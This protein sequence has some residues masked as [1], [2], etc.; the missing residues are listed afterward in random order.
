MIE[1]LKRTIAGTD[2]D[3]ASREMTLIEMLEDLRDM[4]LKRAEA[5]NVTIKKINRGHIDEAALKVVFEAGGR[6]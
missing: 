5:L 1:N 3:C 2:A 4:H 6:R